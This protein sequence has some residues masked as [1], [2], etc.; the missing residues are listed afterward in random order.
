MY[1]SRCLH[2]PTGERGASA[3]TLP[4]TAVPFGLSR[5]L[6]TLISLSRGIEPNTDIINSSFGASHDRYSQSMHCRERGKTR[7][8]ASYDKQPAFVLLL[9]SFA[10]I[11]TDCTVGRLTILVGCTIILRRSGSVCTVHV[12]YISAKTSFRSVRMYRIFDERS[13]K[14]V[15]QCQEKRAS[16]RW[17]GKLALSLGES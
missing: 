9:T 5:P 16:C 13:S 15:A 10:G 12:Q 1:L 8:T 4:R 17:D 3:Y 11:L 6:L 14:L 7:I 2:V